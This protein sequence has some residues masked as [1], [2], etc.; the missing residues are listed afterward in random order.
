[1]SSPNP[2]GPE[3]PGV[4]V[5]LALVLATISFFALAVFGLGAVSIATDSDI[6]AVP[7]LCLLYT[8]PSPRD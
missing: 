1:M 3:S 7:G 4:S 8:S 5:I 6:I 2:R